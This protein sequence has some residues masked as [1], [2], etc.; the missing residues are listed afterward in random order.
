MLEFLTTQQKTALGSLVFRFGQLEH[1]IDWMFAVLLR[2][3]AEVY[4]KIVEDRMLGWKLDAFKLTGLKKLRAKKDQKRFARIMDE[5]KGL[6]G[7]RAIAVHGA[8][9][10]GGTDVTLAE[11]LGLGPFRPAIA[12][13]SRRGGTKVSELAAERLDGMAQR[14]DHVAGELSHFFLDRFIRAP[15]RRQAKQGKPA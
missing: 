8:W 11:L 6:N 1:S 3:D 10:P 14:V 4:N 5:L 15:V 7:E 12:R 2:L 9:R 13:H